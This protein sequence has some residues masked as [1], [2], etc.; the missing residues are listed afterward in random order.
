MAYYLL[1]RYGEALAALDRALAGN[2]ARNTQLMGRPMLAAAYAELDRPEDAARERNAALQLS[3]FL[4][5]ARFARQFGT[6]QARDH[7]L[8]GLKKA[9]FR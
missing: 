1:G 7:M 2:L 3:P 9:G 4:D 5:A 6:T 8:E